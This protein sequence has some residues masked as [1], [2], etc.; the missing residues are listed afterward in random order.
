MHALEN[1]GSG[2]VEVLG[3]ATELTQIL[4]QGSGGLVVEAL[5]ASTVDVRSTSSGDVRV[6]GH[7]RDLSL[8]SAA[9][10]GIF[11]RD[12]VAET[13][14]ARSR[15]SGV[16]ELTASELV[17]AEVAGSGTV[18]VWGEPGDRQVDETGSGQVVF[19]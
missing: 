18:H 7:V 6:G 12:L 13:A 16:I 17:E 14:F 11:A 4:L 19:H 8:D 5:T 10:G 1:S 15:G 2:H 3:E 9:S